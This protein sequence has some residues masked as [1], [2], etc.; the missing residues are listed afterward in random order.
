MILCIFV[1]AKTR[2]I[3][4]RL[5]PLTFIAGLCLE[6]EC[7]AHPA[8]ALQGVGGD[9]GAGHAGELPLPCVL[10]RARPHPD[11]PQPLPHLP[12]DLPQVRHSAR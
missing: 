9:A 2:K 1:N 3:R 11:L 4:T 10:H 12:P 5:S 7:D 6:W 8:P